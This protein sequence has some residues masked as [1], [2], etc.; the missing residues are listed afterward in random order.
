MFIRT[1]MHELRNIIRDKM[2]LFF[3]VYPVILITIALWLIPYLANEV[4][5]FAS[6]IVT[7]VFVLM[8]SFIYGAV[9]GFT[10]LDD[11]DDKV[12]FSLR[13]TPIKVSYYIVIKLLISYIFG[14]IATMAI[15]LTTNFIDGTFLMYILIASLAS[16]QAPFIAL[17]VN[18]FAS[19]KIEGFVVM[20][21]S[22]L[23]LL[24]PIAS[25]FINNWTEFLL[26]I[27]P[28]FWV[29]RIVSME[30]IPDA[31]ILPFYGYFLLGFFYNLVVLYILFVNY[32]KRLGLT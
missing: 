20:K 21:A 29:A 22:G 14:F 30:L 8:T 25:L 4:D 27:V 17:I 2:Y 7:L 10:L 24:L 32:K 5:V 16:L 28:G 1:F 15:L 18:T 12:F 6:Q 23:I 31:Y 3:M 9:T 19:N 26:G 13:I 11:Q